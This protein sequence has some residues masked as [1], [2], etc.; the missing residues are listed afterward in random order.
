MFQLTIF[1]NST[2]LKDIKVILK[3]FPNSVFSI[4][5]TK[6][7]LKILTETGV[8]QSKVLISFRILSEKCILVKDIITIMNFSQN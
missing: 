8:F 6:V 2:K 5:D 4:K 7:I 1:Q 3:F